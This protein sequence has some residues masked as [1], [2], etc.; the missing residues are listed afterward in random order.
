[1]VGPTSRPN[2]PHREDRFPCIIADGMS[3]YGKWI[4]CNQMVDLLPRQQVWSCFFIHHSCSLGGYITSWKVQIMQVTTLI[5]CKK[6]T[7]IFTILFQEYI[8]FLWNWLGR[9]VGPTSNKGGD[10]DFSIR[11]QVIPIEIGFEDQPPYIQLKAVI[12]NPSLPSSW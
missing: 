1:M 9:L 4:T 2:L 12:I 6:L 8:Q 5:Y 10:G 7:R 11:I 3:N